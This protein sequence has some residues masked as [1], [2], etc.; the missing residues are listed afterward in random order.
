MCVAVSGSSRMFFFFSSRR[1]HTRCSR[2]WSSD[3]CSSDLSRSPVGGDRV[4]CAVATK[5]SDAV[6]PSLGQR[7]LRSFFADL[8]GI[9]DEFKWIGILVLL[10]QLEID[11]A[12]GLRHRRAVIEPASGGFQQR[13]G[14][15]V[16]AVRGQSFDG[17]DKLSFRDAEIV[18]QKLGGVGASEMVEA[19]EVWL[20][21]A[22]V[23]IVKAVCDVYTQKQIR[24]IHG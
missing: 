10:H 2:D 21:I 19:L 1:R 17:L 12:S 22:D 20:P 23:L 13:G 14:E 3:V 15:F 5:H 9:K 24:Q 11:E 8:G 16:F 18:N 4:I 6:R 7:Q